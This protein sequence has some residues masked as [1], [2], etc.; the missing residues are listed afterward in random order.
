MRSRSRLTLAARADNELSAVNH[1][2]LRRPNEAA[3]ISD[4]FCHSPCAIRRLFFYE[5]ETT[6]SRST[7]RYGRIELLSPLWLPFFSSFSSRCFLDSALCFCL[8]LYAFVCERLSRGLWRVT[9][10]RGK[11]CLV[12]LV[13]RFLRFRAACYF[14]LTLEWHTRKIT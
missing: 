2:R 6:S 14:R 11:T 8:T 5:S 13:L 7:A 10:K 9:L 3:A 1:K 4:D 12:L